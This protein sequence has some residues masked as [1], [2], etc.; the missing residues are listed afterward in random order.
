M[1]NIDFRSV[2]LAMVA[3]GLTLI[4]Y[5]I[6]RDM[7]WGIFLGN[8]SKKTALRLKG[9]AKGF[10][11]ISQRYMK[12][13]LTKYQKDYKTWFTIKLLLLC[14]AILQTALFVW[15]IIKETA[16][17]KIAIICGVVA[18]INV[19][20]FIVMMSKTESSSNK[21]NTKGSPWKFEQ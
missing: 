12:P 4:S 17:T 3:I 2:L 20:L 10:D 7:L 13:Y 11:R 1:D 16:W 6:V 15:L 9:E 18:V 19:I 5:A 14:F 8:K 21:K